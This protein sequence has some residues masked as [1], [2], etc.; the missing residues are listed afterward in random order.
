MRA[1]PVLALALS[2]VLVAPA[3]ASAGPNGD[4]VCAT[5][6]TSCQP[7]TYVVERGDWL[8]KIA[9]GRL[10][11]AGKSTAPSNVGAIANMIHADN[12]RVIGPDKNRLRVGQ[13]L[14]VRATGQW[15]V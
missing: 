8:W 9:R 11:S 15:P 12:R 7:S 2:A 10:A 13:R 4:P 1:A 6:G 5:D 14:T 3:T